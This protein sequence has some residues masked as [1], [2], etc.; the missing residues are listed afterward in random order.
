MEDFIR[1]VVVGVDGSAES[2]AALRWACDLATAAPAQLRAVQAWSYS[3]LTVVPGTAE[4]APREEMDSRTAKELAEIVEETLGSIPP[5]VRLQVVRGQASEA[6]LRE[7]GPGSLLVVG[8]R[9]MGGF[10]GMLVGSVSRTCIEH[11]PC[12]VVLMRDYRPAGSGVILVGADGSRGATRALTWASF[13]AQLM[14]ARVTVVHAWETTSAEVRPRLHRRLQATAQKSVERWV[15]D[16]GTGGEALSV[17][18]DPR[19]KLVESAARLKADLIVVGR[20]GSSNLTGIAT[21]GV[22]SYLV[23]NSPIPVAVLPPPADM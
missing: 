1:E 13:L 9:G 3:W 6:L 18:G 17:E 2:R 14:A 23:S 4:P 12:P 21:G 11:A 16:A 20:R 19:A 7:V 8:T 10:K 15:A 22:T 5:N